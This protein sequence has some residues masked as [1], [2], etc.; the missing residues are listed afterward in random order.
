[1]VS[2]PHHQP[3]ES[4]E[5]EQDVE[6]ASD[7]KEGH[8]QEVCATVPIMPNL[9][10]RDLENHPYVG[11]FELTLPTGEIVYDSTDSAGEWCCRGLPSGRYTLRVPPYAIDLLDT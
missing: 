9:Q 6:A 5:Y 10:L 3:K 1:M 2:Q 4:S 11:P 8:Y 7:Q